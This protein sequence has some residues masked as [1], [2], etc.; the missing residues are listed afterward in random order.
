MCVFSSCVEEKKLVCKGNPPLCDNGNDLKWCKNATFLSQQN[1]DWV[2]IW[3]DHY[4]KI[5]CNL[6][7]E[8][9]DKV[10]NG[11]WIFETEK[12][13]GRFN[14]LNRDDE[15]RR[16]F[17]GAKTNIETTDDNGMKTN[18]ITE[19]PT[20]D[21]GEKWFQEVNSEKDDRKRRCLGRTPHVSV[22]PRGKI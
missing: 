3:F 15:R 13:D 19:L 12:N 1:H 9:N 22:D 18:E 4:N 5:K 6:T 21:Y 14:C 10:P 17:V 8:L 20:V 2:P 11:Q 16:I 7:H